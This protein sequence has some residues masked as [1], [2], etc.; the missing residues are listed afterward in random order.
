M[1]EEIDYRAI[2]DERL[3]LIFACCHPALSTEAQVALTLRALGGLS[4]LQIARAFIVSEETMKRRLSRAKA[5][6][7]ATGIPFEVPAP[8]L[9]PD[10]LDAVLGVIYL[11]YNE[12]YSG[13]VDLP[14]RR[15]GSTY[16]SPGDA[17]EP[18]AHD[19]LARG[20]ST[21]RA[22]TPAGG[23]GPRAAG[24]PDRDPDESE[25]AAARAI[26]ERARPPRPRRLLRQPPRPL[27]T[28]PEIDWAKPEMYGRWPSSLARRSS[29]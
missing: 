22:A 24:R 23:R 12:G 13:R 2:A 15:S 14:P 6:I 26:L 29:S 20:G 11:I 18:E 4:T 10:R 7:K 3:E 1:E 5:K 17:D 21:T 9:L 25:I 28:E 19:P 27:Q 16:C 8:H